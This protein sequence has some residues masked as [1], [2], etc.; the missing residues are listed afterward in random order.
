MI[1]SPIPGCGYHFSQWILSFW[2]LSFGLLGGNPAIGEIPPNSAL[3][4]ELELV[5]IEQRPAPAASAGETTREAPPIL[6]E[7]GSE[8]PPTPER[9]GGD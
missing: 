6:L 3:I 5:S 8:A 7:S 1:F 4:Y 9:S 2:N